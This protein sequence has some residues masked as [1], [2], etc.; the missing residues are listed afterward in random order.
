MRSEIGV[1]GL[2]PFTDMGP[3]TRHVIRRTTLKM[4]CTT[5]KYT[6]SSQPS[7]DIPANLTHILNNTVAYIV[8]I[9]LPHNR[10]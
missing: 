5:G 7:Q 8:S 3:V 2:T 9:T 4:P 6:N 1:V 10:Q